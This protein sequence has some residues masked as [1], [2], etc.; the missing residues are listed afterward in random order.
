M[1]IT[2]KLNRRCQKNKSKNVKERKRRGGE[3]QGNHAQNREQLTQPWNFS[4]ASF[5]TR[6]QVTSVCRVLKERNH[7]LHSRLPNQDVYTG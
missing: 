2:L 5:N 1:L 3:K 7:V 4:T 6:G